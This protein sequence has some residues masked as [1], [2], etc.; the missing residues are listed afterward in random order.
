MNSTSILTDSNDNS[1]GSISIE[2]ENITPE[3]TALRRLSINLEST[4]QSSDFDFC[5]DA[6][7]I[8]SDSREIQIHRVILASRSPFFKTLF[9]KDK[10][11]KKFE[12][13]KLMSVGVV[14]VGFDS[15]SVVLFYLYSG[16]VKPL[17][18][19]ASACV[20]EECQH[21]G[22]RPVVDL[23]IQVLY[24]SHVFQIPELVSLFQ[25][26]L[27]DILGN[28]IVD[29]IMVILSVANMCD[30]ICEKLVA[31]C[32]DIIVKSDIDSVTLEKGLPPDIFK[33]VMDSRLELGPVDTE[34]DEKAARRIR[35]MHKALDWDDVELI[36]KLLKE[37]NT[38]LDEANA[39][40]YAVAY[41]DAQTTEA[42]LKMGLADVNRRNQRGYTVLHV[43]AMRKEPGIIASIVT[44]G[45]RP[46]DLTPDGRKALQIAKR[47]TK[48]VEYH[49]FTDRGQK[50]PKERLCI[51]ILEQAETNEPLGGEASLSLALAGDDLRER[52]VYLENRVKLAKLFFPEEAQVAMDIAQVK[53]T[54]EFLADANCKEL[55]GGEI[56]PLNLNEAPFFMEELHH[57]RIAA[58]S[59]MVDFGKRY[60]P[61]CSNVLNKIV[62][63]KDLL[64]LA[65]L[66]NGSQQEQQLKKKRFLE[67]QDSLKDAFDKDKVEYDQCK[68]N[69]ASSSSASKGLS[70]RL[71]KSSKKRKK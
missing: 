45:A 4:F 59:R 43:A 44:K 8:L 10:D 42:L 39:L 38:N 15:L 2:H 6:K 46:T 27:L 57:N 12:V 14:D 24:A 54:L 40:H 31:A 61:R 71:D 23:M 22:C 67:I 64:D 3:I 48:W 21:I 70:Q 29:D 34:I 25:R 66:K 11:E 41:S 18:R 55:P 30:K 56:V 60:F 13:K 32:I 7:I 16:K 35:T 19:E 36:E 68:A 9:G 62:D 28:V 20:D 58:L 53:G 63:T 26:R 37:G 49:K 5:S 69:S 47:L 50:A 1:G 65:D 33:Q 51:E 52:W 17:P